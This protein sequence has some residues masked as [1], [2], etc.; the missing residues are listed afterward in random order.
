MNR[1]LSHTS[2]ISRAP[3][4]C[5]GSG[6]RLGQRGY[7]A[8]P[9]MGKVPL[10]IAVSKVGQ[11]SADRKLYKV[12]LN[13]SIEELGKN[14]NCPVWGEEVYEERTKS[15]E[16]RKFPSREVILLESDLTTALQ[17]QNPMILWTTDSV[18]SAQEVHIHVEKKVKEGR[19]GRH[20]LNRHQ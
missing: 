19:D 17:S 8:F 2:H 16:R 13:Q 10:A 6:Y 14:H 12:D 5:V 3:R 7:R 9:S 1:A 4:P 20:L 15:W 11:V 18:Q